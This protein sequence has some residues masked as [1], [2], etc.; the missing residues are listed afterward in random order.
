MEKPTRDFIEALARERDVRRDVLEKDLY[1]QCVLNGI[2]EDE[3]L[4]D[5]LLF[6][7]GTCLIKG[8]LGYFRFS[9]DLDFTWKDQGYRKRLSKTKAK[10]YCSAR[11]S[12]LTERFQQMAKDLD[13]GFSGDKSDPD[14]VGIHA[15]GRMVTFNIRTPSIFQGGS[16]SIRVQIGFAEELIFP[17]VEIELNNYVN[18]IESDDIMLRFRGQWAEYGR[19]ISLVC[20]DERE[21]LIE[22]CR[23]A[24]TRNDFKVRDL[25]DILFIKERSDIDPKE[26]RDEIVRKT[27]FALKTFSW[28]KDNLDK[29]LV[30]NIRGLEEEVRRL[31]LVRPEDGFEERIGEIGEWLNGLRCEIQ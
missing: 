23:A 20:Y 16:G 26:L 29:E 27:R 10:E 28:V 14:D 18:E 8:Y 4:R 21:I 5:S 15:G 24:I 2:S 7:G 9:E 25:I 19:S 11:I 17:S 3:H 1:L 13:M 22:K 30:L 31:L 6:R 12:E